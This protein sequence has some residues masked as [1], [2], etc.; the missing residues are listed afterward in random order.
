MDNI[1]FLCTN[2]LW[3]DTWQM[4]NKVITKLLESFSPPL[5]FSIIIVSHYLQCKSLQCGSF[6]LDAC[7]SVTPLI[8]PPWKTNHFSTNKTIF[9]LRGRSILFCLKP[10]S[11]FVLSFIVDEKI[12]RLW[13]SW[14]SWV[15]CIQQVLD[16][17]Q[18][19]FDCDSWTPTLLFIQN[20]QTDRARWIAAFMILYQ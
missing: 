11:S 13:L 18:H 2:C 10:H 1:S 9:I 4:K 6:H 19:L 14:T 16:P 3:D 8:W 7:C 5:L 12:V 15:W 20:A 17:Q